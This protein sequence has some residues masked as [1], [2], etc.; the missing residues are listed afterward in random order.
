VE[1]TSG[2]YAELVGIRLRVAQSAI[3]CDEVG[4]LLCTEGTLQ[5]KSK[6]AIGSLDDVCDLVHRLTTID[7]ML[8]SEPVFDDVRVY[9]ACT[10]GFRNVKEKGRIGKRR[11]NRGGA[12]GRPCVREV[13]AGDGMVLCNLE[14]KTWR[15][16][17]V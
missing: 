8:V 6:V 14:R 3:M 15:R 2:A 11:R 9:D 17:N 5:E 12:D 1:R 7:G 4:V 10:V 16:M 13:E